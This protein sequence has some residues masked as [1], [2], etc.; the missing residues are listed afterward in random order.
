VDDDM[1]RDF[2]EKLAQKARNARMPGSNQLMA[3][4][5]L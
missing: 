1:I 2:T 5:V 4:L 3:E